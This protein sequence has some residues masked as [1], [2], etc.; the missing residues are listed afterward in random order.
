MSQPTRLAFH[1]MQQCPKPRLVYLHALS[2]TP[3]QRTAHWQIRL[4][5]TVQLHTAGKSPSPYASL[6]LRTYMHA[7]CFVMAGFWLAY[8][9]YWS[10]QLLV[11]DR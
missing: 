3:L 11:L 1:D 7:H 2:C 8:A 5:V 6:A 10:A 4:N 9:C